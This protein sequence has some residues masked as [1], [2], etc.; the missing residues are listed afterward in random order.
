MLKL[1]KHKHYIDYLAKLTTM[2]DWHI[3]NVSINF[4]DEIPNHLLAWL[5]GFFTCL[6]T[7][8]VDD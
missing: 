8:R 5:L 4:F 1:P 7:C 2:T 3:V 6:E